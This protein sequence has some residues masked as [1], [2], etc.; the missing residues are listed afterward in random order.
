M[1][2]PLST[3]FNLKGPLDAAALTRAQEQ[4]ASLGVTKLEDEMGVIL[5]VT[6][7]PSRITNP[8][9]VAKLRA[10]GIPVS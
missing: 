9:L 6:Y 3:H 1:G 5:M 4:L 7:D 10:L 8:V 2:S